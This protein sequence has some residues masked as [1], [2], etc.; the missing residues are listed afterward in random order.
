MNVCDYPKQL[1]R[2]GGEQAKQDCGKV[3]CD[4]PQKILLIQRP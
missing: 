4:F 3:S 1:S 2:I